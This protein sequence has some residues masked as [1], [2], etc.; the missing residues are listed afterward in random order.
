MLLSIVVLCFSSEMLFT[1]AATADTLTIVRNG[2]QHGGRT[3]RFFQ[4]CKE[5]LTRPFQQSK[6]AH[7]RDLSDDSGIVFETPQRAF[8]YLNPNLQYFRTA[9][10][11]DIELPGPITVGEEDGRWYCEMDE[12]SAVHLPTLQLPF[13]PLDP[14]PAAAPLA[15][16]FL[17]ESDRSLDLGSEAAAP[18]DGMPGMLAMYRHNDTAGTISICLRYV[19][20]RPL[21]HYQKDVV[22]SAELHDILRSYVVIDKA[23]EDAIENTPRSSL[24]L[25]RRPSG[26]AL[27]SAISVGESQ[28]SEPSLALSTTLSF[29]ANGPKHV[30]SREDL[31]DTAKRPRQAKSA[32]NLL[33]ATKGPAASRRPSAPSPLRSVSTRSV[34]RHSGESAKGKQPVIYPRRVSSLSTAR[35]ETPP[36]T[37]YRAPTESLESL[38]TSMPTAFATVED[39]EAYKL[40]QRMARYRKDLFVDIPQ[41]HIMSF[42]DDLDN[43]A[44]TSRFSDDSLEPPKWIQSI[45][46]SSGRSLLKKVFTS[47]SKSK[48]DLSSSWSGGSTTLPIRPAPRRGRSLPLFRS[49]SA[50]SE[51]DLEDLPQRVAANPFTTLSR[52][53]LPPLPAAAK[54]EARATRMTRSH[55]IDIM[56]GQTIKE[57]RTVSDENTP[58]RPKVMPEPL[59]LESLD[60]PSQ[61]YSKHT[62]NRRQKQAPHRLS[63][64]QEDTFARPSTPFI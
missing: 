17:D 57:E 6:A 10:Q 39:Y 43:A 19:C 32:S 7:D 54:G 60:V 61:L 30:I 36:V 52:T 28:P 64:I 12:G 35:R 18:A 33:S 24:T 51:S 42:L 15:S 56:P 13:A 55:S 21:T 25:S 50:S 46:M 2:P 14:V 49:E 20:Q 26:N 45:P 31:L 29:G 8:G 5:K 48:E 37:L 27:A 38:D 16:D 47:P 34:R 44:L 11:S 22:P 40:Q 23:A 9:S 63:V 62:F 53:A 59:N 58:R 4:V 41:D 3:K 1:R